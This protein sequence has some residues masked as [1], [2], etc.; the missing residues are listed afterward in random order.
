MVESQIRRR[1]LAAAILTAESVA[2]KH[3]EPG[4]DHALRR[5]HIPGS[6]TT[7]GS[8]ILVDGLRA[9]ASHSA[10]TATA[11]SMMALTALCQGH[12]DSGKYDSAWKSRLR[13]NADPPRV[14]S[15]FSCAWCARPASNRHP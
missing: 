1:K 12:N 10:T 13:T 3:V 5:R 2:Q 9:H 14:T 7:D 11:P 6:A 8:L 15:S 4:E